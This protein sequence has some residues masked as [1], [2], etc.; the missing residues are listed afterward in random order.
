MYAG[1]LLFGV[2]MFFFF[3]F[4]YESRPRPA[5]GMGISVVAL[6]FY[7]L[8]LAFT[9]TILVIS[10]A[11]IEVLRQHRIFVFTLLALSFLEAARIIFSPLLRRKEP[12][13]SS[14]IAN[15]FS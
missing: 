5:E 11:A 12:S 15:M 10:A 2:R 8:I 13:F 6:L 4:V 9:G 14:A 3:V 7:V 1:S